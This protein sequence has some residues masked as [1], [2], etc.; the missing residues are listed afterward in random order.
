MKRYAGKLS[1]HMARYILDKFLNAHTQRNEAADWL[2]GMESTIAEK[3]QAMVKLGVLN[4]RM[5]DFC[6]IWVL[7]STFDFKGEIL[8]EAVEKTFEQRNTPVN[9]N[10]AIFDPSFG[11][12]GNKNVQWQ[13]FISKTNLTNAPE[14]FRTV[15]GSHRC[16]E[17]FSRTSRGLDC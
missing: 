9:M 8:A 4:S 17:T 15:Q 14:S 7:S 10:T 11:K 3:F 2:T 6:D 5:K 13:G 16:C 12:D 1:S